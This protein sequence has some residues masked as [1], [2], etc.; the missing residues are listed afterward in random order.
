MNLLEETKYNICD[1]DVE[2]LNIIVNKHIDYDNNENSDVLNVVLNPGFTQTEF[3][4]VFKQLNFNY[5]N[6]YGCQYVYGFVVFKDGSWLE[7]DSYDGSEDWR[8]VTKP[9]PVG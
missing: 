7:R 6:G 3:D 2:Y 9:Q 1:R 5:N 4:E 8:L